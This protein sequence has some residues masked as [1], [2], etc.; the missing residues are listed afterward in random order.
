[1][2]ELRL[3]H[4]HILMPNSYCIVLQG[5][6]QIAALVRHAKQLSPAFTVMAGG[7]VR[8]ENVAELLAETNVVEVHSSA[9]RYE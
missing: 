6:E 1:M 3:A 2:V 5:A 9:S 8:P 7:S 4:N